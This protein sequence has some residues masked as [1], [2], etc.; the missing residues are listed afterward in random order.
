MVNN[1]TA[2]P[3]PS[4][5]NFPEHTGITKLTDLI[6]KQNISDDKMEEDLI[7]N[8]PS[9]AESFPLN[10]ASLLWLPRSNLIS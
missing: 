10:K 4:S 7:E 2:P 1:S 9:P 6:Q 3:T 8:P 5:Q